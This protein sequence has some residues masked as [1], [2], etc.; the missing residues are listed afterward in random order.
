MPDVTSLRR[1]V[2]RS[3]DGDLRAYVLAKYAEPD[4]G[5]WRGVSAALQADH[6]LIVSHETLRTWFKDDPELSSVD[7]REAS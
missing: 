3:F 5:G 2:E 4:S 7:E 1:M 6:D